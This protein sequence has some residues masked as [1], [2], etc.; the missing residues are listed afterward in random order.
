MTARAAAQPATDALTSAEARPS[1]MTMQG[2]AEGDSASPESLERIHLALEHQRLLLQKPLLERAL[3]AMRAER[4]DDGVKA[5]LE[6]LQLDE[7]SGWAWYILA[8]CRE[9]AG[10]L[11]DALQCYERALQ[12]MPENE[13]LP[14][15]LGRLA[16]RMEMHEIAEKLFGMYLAR[17]PDCVDGANNLASALRG[18]RRYAEALD[19]LRTYIAA[20]PERAQLWNT[21][22]AVVASGGQAAQGLTFMD[23]A[24]RLDPGFAKARYNRANLLMTAGRVREALSECER[25]MAETERGPERAVMALARSQMMLASGEVGAGWDAYEARLDPLFPDVTNFMVHGP[26]WTPEEPLEGR[27]LLVMG[28]QGLGDEVLFANMLPDLLAALGPKGRLLLAVEHR[29]VPL[30]AD[31]FPQAQVI[32]RAAY[33]VDHRVYCTAPEFDEEGFDL[34]TP[35]ASLLRRFRRTV[36]AFPD[37]PAF[38]HAEPDRVAHWRAFLHAQR[39]GPKVGLLW[40]SLKVDADRNRHFSPFE[41]WRPVLEAPGV[42]FINLQYGDCGEEIAHARKALGVEIIQ[43]PGVDLKDE[44]SEVAALSCAMDLVIGPA[45]ATSNIAA[46]CGA[47]VWLVSTPDAWPRLGA[48]RY[49]WYPTMR[50]FEAR[51]GDWAPVMTEIGQALRSR[52]PHR[53]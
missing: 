47:P 2:L 22:G 44:L 40:K 32:R 35:M 7:R 39:P 41:Q 49:P 29:L 38:L 37:T 51:S 6:A 30:F 16:L 10:A 18:Q 50:V 26:R 48:D 8:I 5:A 46:A 27:S 11:V 42:T 23:E 21:L 1:P 34:W 25:A 20:Y 13:E 31:S 4:P 28:E 45:N 43:P 24:L 36:D 53:R 17:R 14:N 12:L 19:V 33:R 9:R 15:D 3:A 52:F